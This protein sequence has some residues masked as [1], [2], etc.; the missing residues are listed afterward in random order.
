MHTY[1]VYIVLEY[2]F[3]FNNK[4][5]F[6]RSLMIKIQCRVPL[7]HCFYVFLRKTC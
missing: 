5:I 6:T 1:N 7:F 4:T 3:R 2:T